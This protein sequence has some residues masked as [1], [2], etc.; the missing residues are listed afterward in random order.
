MTKNKKINKII[1]EINKLKLNNALELIT[2]LNNSEI[3]KKQHILYT[4]I[5]DLSEIEFLKYLV[6]N[7]IDSFN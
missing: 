1:S 2:K 7:P 3:T 5:D 6:K 4:I